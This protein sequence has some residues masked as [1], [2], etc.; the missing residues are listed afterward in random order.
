MAKMMCYLTKAYRAGPEDLAAR[1][2][3]LQP[4]RHK[5][6][7]VFGLGCLG[8]PGVLEFAR[9]GAGCIRLVDHDCVDPATAV[10]WPIGFTA[11]GWKK[12]DVLCDRL[13]QDY[14]YT[15]AEPFDFR[16]GAVRKPDEPSQQSQ[17][18]K[19]I[20]G[21]DLV[22]DAT[23][24]LGVQHFLTDCAWRRGV[25]YVG[26]SGTLGGWGG[27]VFR[28]RRRTGV[29][30]WHCYRLACEEGCI[31]EPAS[32]PDSQGTVQPAGCADPTFTGAGFDMLQVAMMG[33]RMAAATLCE[34]V[35]NAYPSFAWDVV[36]I[37]LRAPNAALI[38]PEFRVY[39]ISA[40]P[41]CPQ[42]NAN[43]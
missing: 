21:A 37:S 7:A 13:A 14:P 24:E 9:S 10:R 26:V 6:I 23:G 25:A 42:C 36:H 4:L 8:A 41:R 38:A 2:P 43:P 3:E 35:L 39:N 17:I 12:V 33:V 29:G 28:I 40:H 20:S 34:G 16:V 19:I 30:C 18:E 5:T 11:A 15:R 31:P 27:K 22:Y 1:I 32:A